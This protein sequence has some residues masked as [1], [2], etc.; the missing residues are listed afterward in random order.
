[1]ACLHS[2]YRLMRPCVCDVN[3]SHCFLLKVHSRYGAMSTCSPCT[4]QQSKVCIQTFALLYIAAFLCIPNCLGIMS[5]LI[6]GDYVINFERNSFR[7]QLSAR[8]IAICFASLP[9]CWKC[10][11]ACCQL[12]SALLL[13]QRRQ[14]RTGMPQQPLGTQGLFWTRI[15][16]HHCQ[17]AASQGRSCFPAWQEM[18][19]HW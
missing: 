10:Q 8:G 2:K 5:Q 14:A 16:N 17:T 6:T 9:P 1:L 18:T 15:L 4:Q 3:M 11:L 19:C 12:G 7:V 13:L